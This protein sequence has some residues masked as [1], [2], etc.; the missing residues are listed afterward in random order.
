MPDA[1]FVVVTGKWLKGRDTVAAYHRDLLK[2][3]YAGSQLTVDN[4]TFHFSVHY[5]HAGQTIDH[6]SLA[7]VTLDKVDG[8]WRID[9]LQNTITG[10]PGYMFG[11]ARRSPR[12]NRGTFFVL[13]HFSVSVRQRCKSFLVFFSKKNFFLKLPPSLHCSTGPQTGPPSAANP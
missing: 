11:N 12:P 8:N 7:T 5:T 9:T 4:V 13:A 6:P 10:G 3:F 1:D 2:T